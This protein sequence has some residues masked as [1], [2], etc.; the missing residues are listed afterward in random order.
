LRISGL[1]FGPAP[2]TKV[3]VTQVA[4]QYEGRRHLTMLTHQ[5]V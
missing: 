5:P 4:V 3:L 1:L 2:Y